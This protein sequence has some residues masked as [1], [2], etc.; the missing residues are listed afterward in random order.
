M[1]DSPRY[2]RIVTRTYKDDKMFLWNPEV[3]FSSDHDI[4]YDVYGVRE[5]QNTFINMK[6]TL[7]F[8]IKEQNRFWKW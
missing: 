2:Y 3:I 4:F 6:N 8:G 5:E 1:K 7:R